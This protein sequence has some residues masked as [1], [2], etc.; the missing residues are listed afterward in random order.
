MHIFCPRL[1]LTRPDPARTGSVPQI[2]LARKDGGSDWPERMTRKVRSIYNCKKEETDKKQAS[3]KNI[4]KNKLIRGIMKKARPRAPRNR[5]ISLTETEKVKYQS[6]LLRLD[7]PVTPDRVQNR[8]ICQDLFEVLDYLPSSF[9][10]LAFIDPPY[11]LNKTFNLTTF[12]EMES[13]KYERWLE[14]WLKKLRRLLK[15]TASV[16]ICGDWKSSGAIFNVL[17]RHFHLRNR[18]TWER[19]K[20][21][22]ASRNWKNC[23]ED[24]W[25]ATVSED[26]FFNLEAVKL[27]RRVL[28]PYRDPSGRPKD[29]SEEVDGRFRVTHPSN[30]WS[31][32]TVPFW[33]MPENTDHPTQKPEKLLAR[34]I[35]A[36]S[37]PGDLVF[38]PFLGSGT[39]SVVAK[40]LGRCYL[41]VEIDEYYCCLA[42]K[43]LELAEQD[44]SIQGY[45]DGVFWERN[46]LA[47][48]KLMN[49]K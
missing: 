45:E 38:D 44:K 32:L 25:F 29:W 43:R 28:A 5:T 8:T 49:R 7:G 27:K 34:I 36:S 40:K 11:N 13:D 18:I 37:C 17:R 20:G 31:D 3:K 6:R 46:T 12:R 47:D 4:N 39:T 2:F 35:L 14:S 9:V 41:G 1:F 22:G 26:Y 16:Y 33:S 24:I 48:R 21:R 30:L 15:P 10:D 42:E 19:E 23:S